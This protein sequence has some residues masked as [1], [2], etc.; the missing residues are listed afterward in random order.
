MPFGYTQ[1]GLFSRL[2]DARRP[3]AFPVQGKVVPQEPDEVSIHFS[4][5]ER[6]RV[7]RTDQINN[8]SVTSGD[9]FPYTGKPIPSVRQV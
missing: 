2:T 8:S 3:K 9:S 1:G 7:L 6:Y 4:L 5:L